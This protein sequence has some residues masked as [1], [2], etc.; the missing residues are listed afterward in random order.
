MELLV[1]QSPRR[2]ELRARLDQ[3]GVETRI[4][5][6]PP[7]HR[8]PSYLQHCKPMDLPNLQRRSRQALALPLFPDMASSEVAQVIEAVRASIL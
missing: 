4:Y 8:Q 5:Y 7:I 2:D 1:L 3:L 6:D